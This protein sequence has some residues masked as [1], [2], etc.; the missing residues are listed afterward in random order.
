MI[1]FFSFMYLL[2][3]RMVLRP[4]AAL[5]EMAHLVQ[6]SK[7]HHLPSAHVLDLAPPGRRG[8]FQVFGPQAHDEGLGVTG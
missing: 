2:F 6:A 5:D 8:L 7:T 3:F 4:R 1:V